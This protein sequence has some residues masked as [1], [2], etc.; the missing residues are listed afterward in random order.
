MNKQDEQ[1]RILC[2]AFH[3]KDGKKHDRKPRNIDTGY[4]IAGR[5]HADCYSI[6]ALIPGNDKYNVG[7][8]GQGFITNKNRFVGRSEAFKIASAAGQ[9]L[10]P[11]LH[12][13]KD[14]PILTSEDLY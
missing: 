7:R 12:Y 2:A 1:E 14:N 4:V 11:K 9:L 6:L 8:D 5:R 10:N 13:N 3:V